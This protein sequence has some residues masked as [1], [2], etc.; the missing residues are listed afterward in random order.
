MYTQVEYEL[1]MNALNA[2]TLQGSFQG[3]MDTTVTML[4]DDRKAPS[5]QLSDAL[6][7]LNG[8]SLKTL[9]QLKSLSELQTAA[10]ATAAQARQAMVSLSRSFSPKWQGSMDV[11]YSEIDAL[12][13]IGNFQAMPATGAQYNVSFQVT[14]SNLYSSRDINGL[15]LSYITSDTLNGTQIAFNNLTGIFENRASFEPSIRF[16]TQND[17]TST[18]VTRVSPGLRLSY[19]LSPRSN[20]MGEAIYETSQTEG[21]SNHETSSSMFFYVGYRYDFQ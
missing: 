5:L 17:N 2:A 9:L 6:I 11:R 20:V 8:T 16:Y 4:V 18:T 10:L 3:P 13:A 7:A 21:P 14:G 1:N 19:K 12:P 15:N